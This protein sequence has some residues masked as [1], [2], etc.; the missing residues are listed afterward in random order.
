MYFPEI[1]IPI[2][3]FFGLTVGLSAVIA[4]E[5]VKNVERK[6]QDRQ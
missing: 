4:G 5:A 6:F 2:A 1:L 3:I